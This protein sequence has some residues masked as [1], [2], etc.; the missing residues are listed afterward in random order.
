MRIGWEMRKAV[1]NSLLWE[2][3]RAKRIIEVEGSICEAVAGDVSRADDVA[4]MVDGCIA[5]FGRTGG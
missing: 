2:R 5:A 1:L 3:F 4:T